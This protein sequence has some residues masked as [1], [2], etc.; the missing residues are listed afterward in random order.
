MRKLLALN[1]RGQTQPENDSGNI[2]SISLFCCWWSGS[3][4]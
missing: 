3:H 1:G 2:L 4:D